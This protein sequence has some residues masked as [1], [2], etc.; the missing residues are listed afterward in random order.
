MAHIGIGECV[1]VVQGAHGQ[2]QGEA[3][4]VSLA[5]NALPLFLG[6]AQGRH[7]D[8]HQN[9]NLKAA[10]LGSIASLEG[11]LQKPTP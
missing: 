11:A 6:I 4:E 1:V 7:E 9:G 8:G 2:R 5:L 3:L 10:P